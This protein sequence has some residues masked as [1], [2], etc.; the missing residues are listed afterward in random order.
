VLCIIIIIIVFIIYT[1]SS[2]S[3]LFTFR[4]SLLCVIPSVA[5]CQGNGHCEE[6]L[7]DQCMAIFAKYFAEFMVSNFDTVVTNRISRARSYL[8]FSRGY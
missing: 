4:Y 6:K 2:V 7:M 3:V 5:C 1:Q 8:K